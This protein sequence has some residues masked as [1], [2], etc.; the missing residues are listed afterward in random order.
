MKLPSEQLAII[1]WKSEIDQRIKQF[2]TEKQLSMEMYEAKN[3][4]FVQ[5]GVSFPRNGYL[6]LVIP[7]HVDKKCRSKICRFD[8][9]H[10]RTGKVLEILDMLAGASCFKFVQSL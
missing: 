7:I 9:V 1:T 6:K 4:S 8:K 10:L 5:P 2:F 3:R